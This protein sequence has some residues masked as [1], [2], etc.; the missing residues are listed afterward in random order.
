MELPYDP[1][2]LPLSIYLQ[3]TKTPVQ[4]YTCTPMSRAALFIIAKIW[5]LLKCL[6]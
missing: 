6:I 3:K 5:K 2:T 4:K 1:A